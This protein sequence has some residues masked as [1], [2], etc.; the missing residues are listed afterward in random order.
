MAL[1]KFNPKP[2]VNRENTRLHNEGG[3]WESDKV[4]FRQGTPEMIGGW[5][6]ISNNRYDGV[7]RSLWTWSDLLGTVLTGVGTHTKFFIEEGGAYYDITPARDYVT[8]NGPFTATPGSSVVTVVAAAHGGFT[9]D[10]V[11]FMGAQS[12]SLQTF[13]VTIASPAV[14]TLTTAMPEDTPVILRTTGALPT[15]LLVDTTYYLVNVVG[16][17]AN[18]ANVPSGA[19]L[20]TSGAQSGVHSLSSLNGITDTL[21]NG[22]WQI[23][24]IDLNTYTIDVGVPAETYDIGDG[25]ATVNTIYNI[26]SG[27]ELAFG[28]TGWGAGPWGGGAWGI[29]DPSTTAMR[30]WSQANFGQDLLYGYRGGPIYYWNALF[31]TAPQEVSITIA[32]PA[33]VTLPRALPDGTALAIITTGALPT[34]L[35]FGTTYYVI[36]S[37]G[38]T[39]NLAA[40]P[41]GAA[42]NTSGSQSGT[43]YISVRGL[44]LSEL[45]GASDVPIAQN[46]ILVSDVSRFVL[47]FG[48]NPVGAPEVDPMFIRWTAQES[49]V[50]WT[51]AADNQAG[52]VRLSQGSKILAARQTRQEIVV[53]TDA[54]VYSLQYLGPPYVWGAT[55]LGDN[56]S[57]VGPNATAVA[58]GITY[59]MGVDKFYRYDGRVQT[60][61]CDLLRYVYDDINLEQADQFFAGTNEGY[62]EIWWFYCS[63][64]STAV[65]RYVIYNYLE[66][67]WYHGNMSRTAWVDSGLDA[68]PV[69]AAYEETLV[70]HELGLNDNVSGTPIA[71]DAY[72]LSSEFDIGDGNVFGFVWRVLPDVTFTGST[73]A[74]PTLTMT[75]YPLKN[76]GSGYNN[77]ASVG[78]TNSGAVIQSVSVPVEQ[79]TGQ[80]NVRIRGRQMALRVSSSQ[81]DTTWQIGSPRIDVR[82]DGRR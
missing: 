5:E 31:D 62:N 27:A 19:P 67:C 12:L 74:N 41:G 49:A 43:H 9:G 28:I 14:V 39:C 77:P 13:T 75:L 44:P 70:Y 73:A 68:Y 59:W 76:S 21:L 1:Q 81:L 60:L 33:V 46:S 72:I 29:G 64:G 55:L 37:A 54:A 17:T 82:T 50:D 4:R 7:C 79:Y 16:L 63:T 45:A 40:T 30:L 20:T 11:E 57:I 10:Y 3:W 56:I 22:S 42:I 61:S 66:N 25:G 2:G 58:S 24:V 80:I 34:G 65:D 47:A 38:N 26:A 52:G 48:V 53:W 36:N 23:T 78:G 51:P 32:S 69:A 15:G 6:Q 8:Y 71:I 35:T 18:L